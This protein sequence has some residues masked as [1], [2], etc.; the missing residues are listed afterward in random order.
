[1]LRSVLQPGYCAVLDE[2]GGCRASRRCRLAGQ[3]RGRGRG[4]RVGVGE[5][6]EAGAAE[7]GKAVR[8][9]RG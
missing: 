6:A 5:G 1:M 4:R 9:C 3:R 7:V 8:Q 2:H